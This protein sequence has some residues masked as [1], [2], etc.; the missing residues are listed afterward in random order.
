[1]ND[2]IPAPQLT[3]W[4][5]YIKL[6]HVVALIIWFVW[7]TAFFDIWAI[8]I[9]NRKIFRRITKIFN[10]YWQPRIILGQSAADSWRLLLVS[11]FYGI[12]N[13]YYDD[14]RNEKKIRLLFFVYEACVWFIFSSLGIF[15]SGIIIANIMVDRWKPFLLPLIILG[16]SNFFSFSLKINRKICTRVMSTPTKKT[17]AHTKNWSDLFLAIVSKSFE[18]SASFCCLFFLSLAFV[19]ISSCVIAS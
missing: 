17:C 9:K 10:K 5:L 19:I 1:M 14:S 4:N 7:K 8:D 2:L 16:K 6:F 18:W 3:T 13:K 12:I 11:H 15:Q